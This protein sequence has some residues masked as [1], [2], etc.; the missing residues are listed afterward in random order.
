MERRYFDDLRDGERLHCQPV[1][2]TREAIIDFAKEFD[3]Q[4]FHIDEKAASE[5]LF[6]GLIASSLHTLSACT[7]VVVEAQGK[8]AILSGV[9]L[10]EVKMFNPVR[11]GDVLSINAWWTELKRS[12][13][14]PDRGF[15]SIKCK[16]ANQRKESV[17]EYGYR[18]L[19]ASRDF[20]IE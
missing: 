16:V 18:Y 15:A 17:I 12:R 14:K 3:P 13:S 9:G 1:E 20:K 6:G 10:H 5:S 7:R 19:I 4:L 2:M 8:V 11:P